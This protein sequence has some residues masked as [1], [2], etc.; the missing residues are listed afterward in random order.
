MASLPKR[1]MEHAQAMPEATP[2]CAG[3]LLHLGNRAA[4]DQALSRLA[5]SGELLRICQ[6]VYMCFVE[7][8]FGVRLPYAHKVIESLSGMW[9]E[10]IVPC[11]GGAASVLGLTTQNPVQPIYFTSGPDR[12]LRLEKLKLLLRHAPRWQL[13]APNRPAGMVIRALS[14][15]YPEEA[16]E[17]LRKVMPKLSAEDRAELLEI[18]AV[19]PGWIAQAV[20]EVGI[21]A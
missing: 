21:N 6:G 14:W 20:S 7:T 10:T 11:G 18:R 5:K 12:E 19:L 17:A 8:H 16:G 9:G 1:I 2:L 13:V 15:L 3:A 4:V